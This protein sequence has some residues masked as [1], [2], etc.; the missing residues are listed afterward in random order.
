MLH[1]LT[2][3]W[4]AKDKISDLYKSLLPNL[5]GLDYTWHIKDNASKD[6][7]I[8][9]IKNWNN[10]KINLIEYGHNRDSYAVGMNRLFKESNANA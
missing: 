7:S 3:N 9:E 8:D 6:G 2:L 5:E 10:S 4:N 1:I